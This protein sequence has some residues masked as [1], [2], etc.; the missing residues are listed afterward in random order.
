MPGPESSLASPSDFGKPDADLDNAIEAHDSV[1][2]VS[3]HR[4][5][6]LCCM[7]SIIPSRPVRFVLGPATTLPSAV[8]R[9][10]RW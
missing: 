6:L 2:I 3:S 7:L 9:G 8:T 4:R 1:S 10:G 5:H